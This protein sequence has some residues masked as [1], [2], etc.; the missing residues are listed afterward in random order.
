MLITGPPWPIFGRQ[1]LH[2]GCDISSM[3]SPLPRA[4][5]F[6]AFYLAKSR[7]GLALGGALTAMAFLN[8]KKAKHSKM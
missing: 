8:K 2:S 5:T 6:A 7:H 3:P 1:G 4:I